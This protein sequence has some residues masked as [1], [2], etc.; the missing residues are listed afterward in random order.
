MGE[1]QVTVL[2]D[3]AL[4]TG[5]TARSVAARRE[6]GVLGLLVAARGAAVSAERMVDVLWGE[7]P[8]PT[9]AASLQVA[10]SRLRGLIEPGRLPR[11]PPRHLLSTPSGYR[12]MLDEDAVDAW[13]LETLAGVAAAA[14]APAERVR[15]AEES[16]A[17]WNGTPYPGLEH[18]APLAA[19]VRR[20]ESVRLDAVE[21]RGQGLL[22]LGRH[23][24]VATQLRPLAEQHPFRE[25]LWAQL[26]LA[27]Y[28]CDRQADA[29][30]A[31]RTLRAHLVD[32]L[33]VD[34]SP[35]V[36][37]LEADVLA[38]SP[39][40]VAPR[41]GGYALLPRPRPT[42]EPRP[43]GMLVTHG[44]QEAL[45]VIDS[46]IAS[47]A[48]GD[49]GVLLLSGEPGIGKSVVVAELA[50]R[51]A[52]AGVRVLQGR[53]HEADVAPAYW[54]WLPVLREV[55]GQ[56]P[57]PELALLTASA[58]GTGQAADATGESLRVYDAAS[59]ALAAAA[60][61]TPLLVVLEDIHWADSSSLRLLGY[62][63]EALTDA[64]VL[65][66]LT[67]RTTDAPETPAL[68][69]A[70][71][72]LG[73]LGATRVP[74]QGLTPQGVALLVAEVLDE[75]APELSAVVAE[76]TDGNPFFV[77]ELARLLAARHA[78]E[79]ADAASLHVPD[80]VRDVLRLRLARLGEPARQVLGAASVVGRAIDPQLVAEVL[81]E[82]TDAVL[83]AL[84]ELVAAGVAQEQDGRYRF[85]HALTRETLY[86]GLPPARR[87]R[88]HAATAVAL[89]ERLAA[90]PELVTDLAHHYALAVAGRPDL[91]GRATDHA[92]AAAR[93]AERRRAHDEACLLWEAAIR[94]HGLARRD[95][96]DRTNLLLTSLSSAQLRA[97]DFEGARATVDRAVVAGRALDRWDLVAVAATGFRG[98]GL[99]HW[100]EF[101][102]L[103]TAMISVLE[104]C[105]ERLPDGPLRA[106]VLASAQMENCYGWQ[107]D[108]VDRY[109]RESLDAARGCGDPDVL[110]D[111]L[112]LRALALWGPGTHGERIALAEELLAT[113]LREEDELYARWQLG[114]ALHQAGLPERSEEQMVRCLELGSRLRYISAEVPLTWWRF[115]R[116]VETD[117]PALHEIARA[118]LA[119]HRRTSVVGLPEL[120]GIVTV[121]TAPG[122]DVPPDVVAGARTNRNPAYRATIAHALAEAGRPDDGLALLG[123]PVPL[124]ARDYA[125]LAGDC[126]RL[127]VAVAAGRTDLV[128]PWL[129]R[130]LPWAGELATYGS[131]DS[132]GSVEY[133]VARA[134]EVLGRA[135]EARVRFGR[136]VEFDDRIGNL[137]WGRR[138]ARRWEAL[139]GPSAATG[140]TGA[141]TA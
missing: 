139:G 29:L 130:V 18:L 25:R 104:A 96:P 123:D 128:E 26:A 74:L 13:R 112:L 92:V 135:E 64:P 45:T 134:M 21:V 127:D 39:V 80:G 30:A 99:W 67:R 108:E 101:G 136:A 50:R 119:L 14:Q 116:A 62:A 7:R 137:A 103:D 8:P 105:L 15:L 54:P 110:T 22:D 16:L 66:A 55:S 12:L 107:T 98:S 133:F 11:T 3:V 85:T 52:E 118:G 69:G 76:R 35:P 31:L 37:A 140:K 9:A 138:A 33:G 41:R 60:S 34:P 91:A 87:L 115:M 86:G 5:S 70:L 51:A 57:A 122:A 38:Q 78:T 56:T 40:L 6:R 17:T 113:D 114:M 90:D 81:G 111:A 97:G 24:V 89:E 131:I 95:D 72:T 77:L 46:A 109:G 43:R 36:Q 61:T 121:R 94:A 63:A 82:H 125:S 68:A 1:L 83:D 4:R 58:D 100:R 73:R 2:G 79:A 120:T 47:L 19:E 106:R 28:R 27:L 48:H 132:V 71:A 84:D 88:W 53:C 102:T 49:G 93:L 59:R 75:P 117:D 23:D 44:R 65:I 20:I 124:G 141:R 32:E 126:L 42:A 10:V 129:Q